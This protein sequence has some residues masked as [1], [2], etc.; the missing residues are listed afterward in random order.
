MILIPKPSKC[1]RKLILVLFKA[2]YCIT[3]FY[4]QFK[5]AEKQ[6]AHFL[7]TG[8]QSAAKIA[9]E[10]YEESLGEMAKYLAASTVDFDVY[11]IVIA[12][13][14]LYFVSTLFIVG[15]IY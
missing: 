7:A 4:K 10:F 15:E 11:S 2:N 3:E 8:Q 14:L 13:V 9:K 5:R 1:Q 6:F 12:I